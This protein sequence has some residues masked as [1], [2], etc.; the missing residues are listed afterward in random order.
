MFDH[1]EDQIF[2]NKIIGY[3]LEE[4]DLMDGNGK[5]FNTYLLGF[6]ILIY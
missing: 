2:K 4:F 5:L 6:H 3:F 1:I